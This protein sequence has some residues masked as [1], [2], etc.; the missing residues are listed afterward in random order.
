MTAYPLSVACPY[1]WV[2]AW[3]PCLRLEMRRFRYGKFQSRLVVRRARSY[4]LG[5]I[6]AA[7][8]QA[9]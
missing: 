2:D 7:Q 3:S 5:R 6:R 9:A 8:A 1:C 4:H